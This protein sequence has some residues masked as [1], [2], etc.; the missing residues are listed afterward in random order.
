MRHFPL[1]TI[2][3]F[4]LCRLSTNAPNWIFVMLMMR[5]LDVLWF[6]ISKLN[7]HLAFI[8]ARHPH[9]LGSDWRRDCVSLVKLR[10][11]QQAQLEVLK[12]YGILHT[13]ERSLPRGK[14]RS[15]VEG[16]RPATRLATTTVSRRRST[17]PARIM[18]T[19]H[20]L[21]SKTPPCLYLDILSD[22][23]NSVKKSNNQSFCDIFTEI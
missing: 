18:S 23:K 3:E 4:R 15:R 22:V 14:L 12:F 7:F 19:Y 6:T 21:L 2:Q 16:Q 11:R 8:G 1:I 17:D 20:C 5:C 10:G 13:G 9:H